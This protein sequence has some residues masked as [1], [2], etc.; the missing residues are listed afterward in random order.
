VRAA[1]APLR[2]REFR[3]LF[4]A[5]AV[6]IAGSAMAPIAL[7]FGVLEP[8]NALLR[9]TLNATNI[10]GAAV[11]GIVVAAARPGWALAF[12]AAT[13]GAATV[14]L[15]PFRTTCSHASRRGTRSARGC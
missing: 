7:A 10:G 12:D 4:G 15:L 14:L 5:R 6:S 9:L 8:A 3:L 1:L 11:G 2:H 13:Y